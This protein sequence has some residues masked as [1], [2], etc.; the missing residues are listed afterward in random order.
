[1][2]QLGENS[3]GRERHAQ[4]LA[5]VFKG[6]FHQRDWP[7]KLRAQDLPNGL[8]TLGDGTCV[9]KRSWLEVFCN[10]ARCSV[11]ASSSDPCGE[12]N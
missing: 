9:G 11:R 4:L 5:W 1:M 10:F 2:Q 7:E 12:A 3:V 8:Q 6:K